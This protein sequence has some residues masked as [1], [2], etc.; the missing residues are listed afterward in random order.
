MSFLKKLFG[1]QKKEN[2][3]LSNNSMKNSLRKIMKKRS[4]A[5]KLF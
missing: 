4:K 5:L 3:Y 1:G 2:P